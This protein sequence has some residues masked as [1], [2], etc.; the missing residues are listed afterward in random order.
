MLLSCFAS[1]VNKGWKG[2]NFSMAIKFYSF[3]RELENSAPMSVRAQEQEGVPWAVWVGRLSAAVRCVDAGQL[4]R[5]TL[6]RLVRR[7]RVWVRGR[8]SL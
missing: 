6:V 3:E 8:Y 7:N 2:L 1:P 5:R 4:P